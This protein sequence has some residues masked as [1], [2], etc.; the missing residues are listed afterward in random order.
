MENCPAAT[1]LKEQSENA[2]QVA[3]VSQ[4]RH[5]LNLRVWEMESSKRV[6]AAAGEDDTTRPI[7]TQK[8]GLF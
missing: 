2:R 6:T 8:K 4:Q 3:T 7:E 1:Q 5:K